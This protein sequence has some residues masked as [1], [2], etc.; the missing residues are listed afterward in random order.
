MVLT[1]AQHIPTVYT[2]QRDFG[3]KG[4]PPQTPSILEQLLK[5]PSL[6]DGPFAGG[7]RDP[8]LFIYCRCVA[9]LQ[10]AYIHNVAAGKLCLERAR[11]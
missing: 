8:D 3:E 6:K 5:V 4:Y 10:T 9:F 11:Y 7:S 2:C 1:L